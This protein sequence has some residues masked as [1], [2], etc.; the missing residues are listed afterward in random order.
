MP[1][2]YRSPALP[3]RNRF[4]AAGLMSGTSMDGVDAALVSVDADPGSPAVELLQFVTLD[5]PDE[6]HDV[7]E[8]LSIGHD[9]TAEEIATVNTGVGVTFSASFFEVCRRA[10]MEPDRVDFI[11]S[12]GQTVAHVPPDPAAG[13]PIVG[14][15]QL[16]SPSIVAALTGVTTVGDFRTGDIALGGQGA[17]LAPW[18]DYLLRR[19]KKHSRV[20][21]NIGGIANLTYLPK[22]CG[23]DDVV[24]FDTGP[25][26]MVV[27]SLFQALFPGK[28]RYDTGGELAKQGSA[29]D[30]LVDEFLQNPF[31]AKAP[32]RSAGHREFGA[33]FAWQFQARGEQMG[34]GR[35]DILASG[36]DL[37]TRTIAQAIRMF[38]RSRGTVDTVYMSGGGAR[39]D[40]LVARLGKQLGDVR[41]APVDELGIPAEAKEAVDFAVLARESL[42]GRPNVLP[43]VTGASGALVLGSIAWGARA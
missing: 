9:T 10:G 15:L 13:T 18:A 24:A 31:F 29:S 4:V 41:C 6:L 16:G 8:D 1:D 38:V 28:G 27:D 3:D 14:T 22:G 20:V 21:L 12:H 26:N 40:T 23:P 36:V 35:A 34:L 43:G 39:N 11:G 30:E 25:G 5:Y 2:N 19:S 17:P 37:T 42:M 33:P 7:L 32:P